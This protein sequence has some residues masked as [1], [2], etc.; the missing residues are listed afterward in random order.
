MTLAVERS[1]EMSGIHIHDLDDP[2]NAPNEITRLD[3]CK[4]SYV[5]TI[6]PTYSRKP[7]VLYDAIT[8]F[9]RRIED[10]FDDIKGPVQFRY[11]PLRGDTD[12]SLRA[13]TGL[14]ENE[15]GP[16]L[17]RATDTLSNQVINF[18]KDGLLKKYAVEFTDAIQTLIRKY[19]LFILEHSHPLYLMSPKTIQTVR[20]KIS[21]L[22]DDLGIIGQSIDHPIQSAAKDKLSYQEEFLTKVTGRVLGDL[23]VASAYWPSIKIQDIYSVLS[24]VVPTATEESILSRKEV[25]V[26]TV[27]RDLFID[28]LRNKKDPR[29]LLRRHFTSAC[30]IAKFFLLEDVEAVAEEVSVIPELEDRKIDMGTLIEIAF[31]K[32][33]IDSRQGFGDTVPTRNLDSFT[34]RG[35][36]HRQEF[37]VDMKSR[38][39]DLTGFNNPISP[40]VRITD[41]YLRRR[42]TKPYDFILKL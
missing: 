5:Q 36:G 42:P 2:E 15:V 21:Q 41:V 39:T 29:G 16:Y 12:Q 19:E 35:L 18:N 28:E 37:L 13:L 23:H 7:S 1:F 40:N 6:P 10:P 25:V 4:S 32:G 34:N 8:D 14:G 31:D 11:K 24:E 17:L 3:L 33:D 26:K 30:E 9:R 22:N 38:Y 27:G 20:G